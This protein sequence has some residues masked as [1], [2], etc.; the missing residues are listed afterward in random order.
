MGVWEES[1]SILTDYGGLEINKDSTGYML[2]RPGLA[3]ECI[4][5]IIAT[6]NGLITRH[7]TIRLDTMFQAVQLPACIA[8]LNTGLAHVDRDTFTLKRK[9]R[10]ISYELLTIL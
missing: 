9:I 10:I 8:N 7:L 1:Y 5:S 3:E 2:P 6:S 4:E